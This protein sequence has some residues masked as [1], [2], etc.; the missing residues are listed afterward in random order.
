MDW[1]NGPNTAVVVFFIGLAGLVLRKNM[2]ISIIA[3]SIMNTAIILFFVTLFSTPDAVPPMSATQ[4]VGTADPVPQALMITS[5]VI[6]L[7]VQAV[8]LVLILAFYRQHGTLDWDEAR[9]IR[10]NEL[11]SVGNSE[12]SA[13]EADPFLRVKALL[14]RVFT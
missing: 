9:A 13:A 5:V 6:G 12:V 4:I 2:M 3:V 8:S 10:E 7:A 11:R 14:E 1:L